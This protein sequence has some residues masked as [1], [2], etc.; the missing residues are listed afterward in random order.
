MEGTT[1]IITDHTSR[2]LTLLQALLAVAVVCAHS[3]LTPPNEISA[4]GSAIVSTISTRWVMFMFFFISGYLFFIRIR[5]YGP[6]EYLDILRHKTMTL[7]VPYIAWCSIAWLARYVAE[8]GIQH[9]PFYNLH[10]TFLPGF[11]GQPYGAGLLWFMLQLMVLC[12][13]SPLIHTAVK[14]LRMWSIPLSVILWLTFRMPGAGAGSN[15]WLAFLI[16]ASLAINHVDFMPAMKRLLLPSLIAWVAVAPLFVYYSS[17]DHAR[18]IPDF[19]FRIIE[20]AFISLTEVLLLA[21]ASRT[22]TFIPGSA[23]HAMRQRIFAAAKWFMP[24]T[25]FIYVTH[26]FP[27]VENLFL[28]I[29]AAAEPWLPEGTPGHDLLYYFLLVPV[30][31]ALLTGVASLISRVAP[32]AWSVLT[33]G[34]GIKKAASPEG[35]PPYMRTVSD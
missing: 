30:R 28:G 5:R 27:Q 24:F 6:H 34:R 12:I 4:Y 20:T 2:A 21:C 14:A 11:G 17:W 33:G 7:L 15:D 1:D 13:A 8:P 19:Y 23:E 16:G 26:T 31:I 3:P 22:A 10:S 18:Q 35:K 32:R 25:F 9:P 29:S